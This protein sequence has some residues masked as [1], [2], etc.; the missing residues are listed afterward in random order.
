MLTKF[1]EETGIDKWYDRGAWLSDGH[2]CSWKGVA[3]NA[4]NYVT[5]LSFE[6][7]GL[8]QPP[9]SA[10]DAIELL[11]GMPHLKVRC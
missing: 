1:A 8:E 7:N 4:L 11:S 3:C 6:D 2:V 9:T 10:I 5:K